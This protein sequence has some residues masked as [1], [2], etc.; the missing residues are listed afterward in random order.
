MHGTHGYAW[1]DT[2]GRWGALTRSSGGAVLTEAGEN[3]DTQSRDQLQVLFARDFAD[4]LD[5]DRKTHPCNIDISYHGF[6]IAEGLYISAMEH[7]RVDLPLDPSD[8]GDIIAR[9][10]SE[11]PHC[12]EYSTGLA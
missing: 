10:L 1:C 9:M 8:S 3:W 6:E 5:D 11:L 4:W 12:P 2:D 7:R